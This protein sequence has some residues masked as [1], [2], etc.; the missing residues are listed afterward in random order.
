MGILKR[1]VAVV[2]II[3]VLT[4]AGVFFYLQHL[5]PDYNAELQLPGLKDKVEVLYD[6]YGIPHIYA[7]SE[8]DLFYAFGYVHAQD[9]LFQMEIL[10]R[11][12]DGRLAELFG[13]KALK[14]DK[15]FR[16][17]SFREHAKK[18][19]DSLYRDSTLPYVKAAKNY[20]KGLN[21]YISTGK[22]P[23][24]FTLAGI[25]K[26]PFEEE[27]MQIIMSY[28]GYTFLATFKIEPVAT[29]VFNKL[30]PEY[31][32]DVMSQWPDSVFRIPVAASERDT[33]VK[34][35]TQ[36]SKA[37]TD[38]ENSLPYPT[39]HGSNGWVISGKKTKSGKPI[40]AN[41]T[42]IQYA[43]PSVWY[44]A[45]LE[46]PGF[47]IY[48][49]F[50]A[51]T[52]V[53]ALGHTA[54]GGWGITMF[55]ND[56]ADM[57]REKLNPADAGQVWFKDHWE[58]ITIRKEMIKVKGE[59]D[60]ALNVKSS[61]HGY[62]LNG[63]LDETDSI[64]DPI[65]FWWTF[66]QFPSHHLKG[67]YD[68]AHARHAGDAAKAVEPLVAPGLNIMWADTAGNIAWWASAKLPIRPAHTDPQRMLD[69]ASGNDEI[70]GW[71]DFSQNPQI[72]NPARGVLYTANNQPADMGNGL[73]PGYYVPSDR[74]ERIE[75]LLFTDKSDWTESDNRAMINDVKA[76]S[77]ATLVRNMLSS[78]DKNTLTPAAKQAY[79]LLMK[80]DGTHDLENTEPTIYYRLVYEAL[81]GALDD[82]LGK[83][84]S[85]ALQNTYSLRRNIAALFK[86]DN[87]KWWDDVGTQPKETRGQIMTR[88]LNQAVTWL[89]KDLGNDMT[90]W[91]WKRVHTITH[92]HPL[93]ILPLVGKYFSVGP[94]P[95]PGGRETLNNTSFTLDST[96]RYL[97]NAG[98]ALRR[99][100][101]F[102]DPATG[103]SVNP[104]GQSGY[105]MSKHYDDQAKMFA[106]GG[107]RHE[108]MER[109]MIEKVMSGKTVFKP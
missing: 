67:F 33:S 57:Y 15:F 69:G 102:S 25:P 20:L 5:K 66:Y 90:Q 13:E 79:E 71:Y 107:K 92:N 103:Y 29:A 60:V 49:N 36:I 72:L 43:Q 52:P 99:V 98:P 28:I 41:D 93:G 96:G 64:K 56:D 85:V 38:I 44:E 39:L 63:V 62:F 109:K 7:S 45:H 78:V 12:A 27:D 73:I 83:E 54:H 35:L 16:T 19:I 24:E 76:T 100:I 94:I 47:S 22:T 59:P 14:S 87:S 81:H 23:I 86:K 3:I 2:L 18:T 75:E 17:L 26:T 74:S 34:I 4:A 101:D 84:L 8:E 70:L 48:G 9:R 10:R 32:T 21:H 91:Q 1:I 80:W 42:H 77:H 68:L 31:Y 108:L 46:C 105:F 37:I 95:I 50:L 65:A 58:N 40:L 55:E 82:E 97:V 53:P 51:G 106:E 88:S 11:L 89:E 61:R 6:D 104:T 30:G